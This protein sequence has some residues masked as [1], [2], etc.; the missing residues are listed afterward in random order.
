MR[1]KTRLIR[2]RSKHSPEFASHSQ[3]HSMVFL[4]QIYYGK[5]FLNLMSI[6]KVPF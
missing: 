6:P 1:S 4:A 3:K 5:R 2:P